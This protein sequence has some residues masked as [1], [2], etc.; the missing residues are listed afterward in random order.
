MGCSMGTGL[1]DGVSK[2]TVEMGCCKGD[3][4]FSMPAV[5]HVHAFSA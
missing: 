2:G 5:H 4:S 1:E 3:T